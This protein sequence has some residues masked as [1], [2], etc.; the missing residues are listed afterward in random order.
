MRS[1]PFST[2][3]LLSL[4]P[5]CNRQHGQT[6]TAEPVSGNV[7]IHAAPSPQSPIVGSA[8]CGAQ[9]LVLGGKSGWRAVRY[10]QCQGYVLNEK[11]VLNY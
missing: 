2:Y 4:Q 5:P 7:P 11:I 9:L 10:D 6:A 8:P 3:P 1:Q